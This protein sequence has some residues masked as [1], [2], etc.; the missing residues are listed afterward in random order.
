MMYSWYFGGRLGGASFHSSAN[1]WKFSQAVIFRADTLRKNVENLVGYQN[2]E[3]ESVSTNMTVRFG[4]SLGT[5][6]S[7]WKNGKNKV[8]ALVIEG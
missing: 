8:R 6:F 2:Q 4:L 5:E 7:V 1:K 3:C